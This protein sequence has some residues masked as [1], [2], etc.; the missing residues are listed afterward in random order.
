MSLDRLVAIGVAIVVLSLV[1]PQIAPDLV[2]SW[3][4]AVDAPAAE[5]RGGDP[6]D[7]APGPTPAAKEPQPV[8]GYSRQ[9]TLAADD[10]G[11]YFA[12]ATINGIGVGVM[13]DTG[14]TI[15]ALTAETASRLGIDPSP[16]AQQHRVGMSTANGVV[17]ATLVT[18]AH[19]RLGSVNVYNV[20][21]AVMP[22][23]ALSINLLGMS[24]LSKLSRFQA[25][26]GQ[27]VLVE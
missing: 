23:G 16:S 2:A 24:F 4:A 5:S 6:A 26:G 18:L 27:L 22:P 14:A 15:V 12:E 21:A 17:S 9:A 3:T 10:S 19:V 7:A 1:A 20:Q 8:A 13:I 25:A 11:H